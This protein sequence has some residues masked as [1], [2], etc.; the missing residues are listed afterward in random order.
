MT[1]RVIKVVIDPTGAEAGGK[2]VRR[3]VEGMGDAVGRA[4]SGLAKFRGSFSE[5]MRDFQQGAATRIPVVGQALAALGPA[6]LGAAAA[7]A[8]LAASI[9]KGSAASEEFA[10]VQ[11][12]LD[13]TLRG[14]GRALAITKDEAVSMAY[15]LEGSLAISK[16]AIID[17]QVKLA[18]FG[19]VTRDNFQRIIQAAADVSA[20]FK[21]D[22]S[23]NVQNLGI[24]I[25]NLSEGNVEGLSRGFRF[26]GQETI[27]TIGAMAQMGDTA[28]ATEKLLGEI[29]AR[30]GGAA[31]ADASGL[32]GSIFRLKDAWSEF[33]RELAEGTGGVSVYKGAIEGLTWLI[34]RMRE[35]IAASVMQIAVLNRMFTSGDGIIGPLEAYRQIQREK[36]DAIFSSLIGNTAGFIAGLREANAR[37]VDSAA[38]KAVQAERTARAVDAQADA[39]LRLREREQAIL[40]AYQERADIAAELALRGRDAAELLKAQI[41]LGREL[42]DVERERVTSALQLA[43]IYEGLAST[44]RALDGAMAEIRAQN[45]TA[46]LREEPQDR[47][48]ELGRIVETI[49]RRREAQKIGESIGAGFTREA[50]VSAQALGSI[51]GGSVGQSIGRA[52]AVADALQRGSFKAVTDKLLA[53]L[54]ANSKAV[55]AAGRAFEGAELGALIGSFS[56]SRAGNVGGS[57][58][59]ALGSTLGPIGSLVGSVA[60]TLF[61]AIF[62]GSRRGSVRL[63]TSSSGVLDVGEAVGNSAS[64]KIAAEGLASSFSASLRSIVQ[65]VGGELAANVELGTIGA[66]GKKFTF[67]PSGRG[68]TKGSGVLRF[69]DE[70]SA[71]DAA[72]RN[73]LRVGVIAGVSDFTRRLLATAR[74]IDQAVSIASRWENVL[75]ELDDITDPVGAAIR[76]VTRDLDQLRREMTS[77][78]ATAEE[79]NKLE[80]V[81]QSRLKKAMDEQLSSLRDLQKSLFGEG[82]GLTAVSRLSRAM[83][84]YELQRRSIGGEGFDQAAFS[85]AGQAVFEIAREVFGTATPEFQAIRQRLIEDTAAAI[86]GVESRFQDNALLDAVSEQSRIAAQSYQQ[87]TIANAYL[88][89]IAAGIGS[90]GAIDVTTNGLLARAL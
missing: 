83:S 67:D 89:K 26:L 61:G 65:A 75:R 40:G 49:R 68:R 24:A 50:M 80:Q 34:N 6:S 31:A 28:G 30:V 33:H 84:D 76:S 14:S 56:G 44:M 51:I 73:A 86:S 45:L 78:G 58:G 11:R 32:T 13:V 59:G 29:E 19:G 16:E 1:E 85:A 10:R 15:A 55:K 71:I 48:D 82:S 77:F 79:L 87:L 23:S 7:F 3:A 39:A 42:T 18:T 46:P 25:Q 4:E 63:G 2:R 72:V 52:I 90:G 5:L 41:A 74:D 69:K 36:S 37:T 35:G 81:L 88:A 27:N 47:D 43:S 54:G 70:E 62:G 21:G 53:G 17:A 8:V 60:G 66:R 9:V 20:V 12:R 38:E 57:V 64:R 22:L